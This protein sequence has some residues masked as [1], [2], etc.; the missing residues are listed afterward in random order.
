MTQK[1]KFDYAYVIIA[2]CFLMIFIGLGFCSSNN[3]IYVQAITKALGFKRGVF[4]FK[5]SFRF[6]TTSVVSL[7]FGTLVKKFGAKKLIVTGFVSLIGAMVTYTFA[8]EIWHFFGGSILLGIGMS[9]STTGMVGYVVD[10]WHPKNKGTIMGA[11]LAANGLGGA[12]AAKIVSPMIYDE[13]NAFGYRN[14]YSLVAIILAAI[15]VLILIFFRNEP[16]T[17]PELPENTGKKKRGGNWEGISFR[18]ALRTPYFYVAAGTVFLTGLVLQSIN[19]VAATHIKDVGIDTDF[20]STVM[21]VHSI[22]LAL[23]KFLTGFVYDRKGLRFTMILCYLAGILTMAALY[24][25]Q[26]TG[27]GMGASVFY[28]VVSSLALPLETVM[29]P[30][31]TG[32]LFGRKDYAK[33]LGIIVAVNTAGYAL[34]A[35]LAGFVFDLM[36]S[37]RPT[38]VV[39]S[40]IF[41][42]LVVIVQF[43]LNAANRMKDRVAE[44]AEA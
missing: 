12:L 44:E 1:R 11:V 25:I 22:C 37:Y 18:K 13:T 10:K 9:F 8:T 19:G 33:I 40:V 34:G 23:F 32:D 28:A 31:I 7:F 3:S 35:P 43:T 39:G 29:L 5:E 15:A 6:V 36:G 21:S 2:L 14:A 30:I 26:P 42:V 27:F 20:M 16:K 41:A 4:A 24:F 38:F 17:P